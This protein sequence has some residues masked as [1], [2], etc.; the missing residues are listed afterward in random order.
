M[1]TIFQMFRSLL[2][3]FKLKAHLARHC[4]TAHGLTIRTST[5][6]RALGL[7]TRQAFF[8]LT[9]PLTRLSRHLCKKILHIRHAARNPF[10]PIN[11]TAIKQE[12]EY[13][14]L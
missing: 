2:Q 6:P 1:F 5:N 13:H 12:C 8:L 3:E 9:T 10:D 7:K 11:V 14:T 4:Q